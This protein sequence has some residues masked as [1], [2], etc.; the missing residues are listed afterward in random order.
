[1]VKQL[2]AFDLPNT[3]STSCASDGI[4]YAFN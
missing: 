1:M 3:V 4:I 2:S